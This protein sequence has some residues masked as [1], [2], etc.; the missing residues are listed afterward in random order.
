MLLRT[1]FGVHVFNPICKYTLYFY[2]IIFKR[3]SADISFLPSFLSYTV[4][5]FFFLYFSKGKYIHSRTEQF[6]RNCLFFYKR[7]KIFCLKK[8]RYLKFHELVLE[9]QKIS[10]W[11]NSIFPVSYEIFL[12]YDYRGR[13]I[14][15]NTRSDC[16]FNWRCWRT[17]AKNRLPRVSLFIE[18]L[19]ICYCKF[20]FAREHI[21][22]R[23]QIT[24]MSAT[25]YNYP[26]PGV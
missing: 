18:K 19:K 15:K 4:S 3:T 22:I 7:Y 6:N 12:I 25:M 16:D 21:Y 5:P 1:F 9:S 20:I 10:C 14:Q 2:L 11:A 24:N 8:L 13:A 17:F 23:L 26:L